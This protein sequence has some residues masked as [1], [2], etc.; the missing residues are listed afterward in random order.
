MTDITLHRDAVPG[1]AARITALARLELG[2]VFRSRW[3]LFCGGLYAALAAIFVGVGMHESAVVR[4]TG[5]D[6]VLLSLSHALIVLLPLLAL[7]GTGLVIS[8]ARRDGT[9][10]LLF[11]HPIT[12]EDYFGA[13]TLVRF[14]ALVVP[15]LVLMPLLAIVGSL[16]FAQP[17]P[18]AFLARAIT[19]SIALLWSFVGLG[20]ALSARVREPDRVLIYVLLAWV[21]GVALLDFG[22][23]GLMLQWRL[24]AGLVFTL[25]GV[26]PVEA[27]RLALVAGAEP[28]L[29]T[30]GPVGFFLHGVIGSTWL[31]VVGIVWPLVVGTVGWAIARR[32]IGR[33]DLI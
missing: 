25:A 28:T 22:L 31:L 26:N 11:S 12:R 32:Q 17:V 3:L 23:A 2:E 27:A 14:G 29:A 16:V 6:R 10:E 9:L 4:F 8:R 13:V 24:P 33:G 20:L 19:V 7:T 5:M 30:L 21:L 1:R 15:L 18:W